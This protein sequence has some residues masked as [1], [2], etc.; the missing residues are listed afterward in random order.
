MHIHQLMRGVAPGMAPMLTALC[1]SAAHL[2][3]HACTPAATTPT[4]NAQTGKLEISL[5]NCAGAGKAWDSQFDSSAS[6]ATFYPDTNANYWVTGLPSLKGQGAHW[7]VRGQMPDARFSSLQTYTFRGERMG[8]LVDEDYLAN[9]GSVNWI[10]QSGRYSHAASHQYTATLHQVGVEVS[11]PKGQLVISDEALG[12]GKVPVALLAYRVYPNLK[13]NGSAVPADL[14]TASWVARGQVAL[15]E[16]VYVVDDAALPHFTSSDQIFKGT[17]ASTLLGKAMAGFEALADVAAP[18]LSQVRNLPAPLWADPVRWQV[19]AGLQTN[20]RGMIN[21]AEAP[22]AATLW[23]ASL[24]KLPNF[25]GFDNAATR[26]F[27]GGIHPARGQVLVTRFKAATVADPD[28]GEAILPAADSARQ[29]RYWSICLNNT[30]SLYV[31]GCIR[32]TAVKTDAHGDVTLVLSSGSSA[33]A[34]P[35]GLPAA[36]WL[37]H[38][39]P[40]ELLL[41]RYMWASAGFTASPTVYTGNADDTAALAAWSQAHY[42][43]STY[44]SLN[45]YRY[46]ACTKV[47]TPAQER[48]YQLNPSLLGKAG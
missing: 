6:Q 2:A 14:K 41:I 43:R 20:L 21:A 9:P 10:R 19:N 29:V 11:L 35:D 30:L 1:L 26:Y 5:G 23:Q 44:C 45:N 22:M 38:A 40:N 31:T 12:S 42:P 15:P 39:S 46:N 16:I 34:G 48:L 33:P 7:E 17:Q 36:N 32:D 13:S 37:R 25:S 24:N 28:R 8:V 18:V 47:F 27:V 3:A 4:R